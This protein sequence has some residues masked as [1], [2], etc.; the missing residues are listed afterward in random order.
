MYWP[1]IGQPIL[2]PNIRPIFSQYIKY[3][4]NS[5]CHLFGPN[6]GVNALFQ[7]YSVKKKP[8][9]LG[10]PLHRV[11]CKKLGPKPA[12]SYIRF[13]FPTCPTYKPVPN[14]LHP[15]ALDTPSKIA[16][17]SALQAKRP[18]DWTTLWLKNDLGPISPR[19]PGYPR[20]IPH[21]DIRLPPNSRLNRGEAEIARTP[22][23]VCEAPT[24][25]CSQRRTSCAEAGGRA[26]EGQVAAVVLA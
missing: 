4:P 24:E 14:S 5:G 21:M 19:P 7:R 17:F 15:I 13:G 6:S 26:R 12:P 8:S 11:F 9:S 23:V 3:W 18:S 22:R 25:A 10:P 16:F 1:N 20:S 2:G